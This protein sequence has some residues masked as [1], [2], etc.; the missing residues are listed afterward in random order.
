MAMEPQSPLQYHLYV[1]GKYQDPVF[2]KYRVAAEHLAT[3]RKDVK[4]T[5][6]GF[7]ETQFEQHLRSVVNEYGGAFTQSKSSS[8]LA[9]AETSDEKVLYFLNENRFFDWALKRFKYEDSTRLIFYKHLGNKAAE[10][11]KASTGRSYC[12]I[13]ITIGNE[14][15]EVVQLELFDE[16]CPELCRNFLNVLKDQRFDG[17][18]VHRVKAG[19]WLQAGDLVDGSGLNSESAAGGMLR[20]ESFKIPH[21]RAGLLGM[22]CHGRDCIGSQFYITLK[23]LNFLNG[24]ST[25]FGR[26]ISGMRTCLKVGRVATRNERPVENIVVT[27][28]SEQWVPGRIQLS[29]P[30]KG[31]AVSQYQPPPP[32]AGQK[33]KETAPEN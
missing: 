30:G 32:K 10:A 20:H 25:I 18:P 24:N 12:A 1:Y 28:L 23:D 6:R 14:P 15:Q 2:Q 16:E 31:D 17:H 11:V 13:G 27:N 22:S 4:A 19:A 26:V 7:L 3:V 33:D 8:A 21:D 29:M 5:I 9:F